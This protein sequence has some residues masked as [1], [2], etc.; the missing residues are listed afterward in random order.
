MVALC[1][2]GGVLAGF[3]ASAGMLSGEA[4]WDPAL[5]REYVKKVRQ[6]DITDEP[7]PIPSDG[8]LNDVCGEYALRM[9]VL[10]ATFQA[11]GGVDV[12][13]TPRDGGLRTVKRQEELYAKC[14]EPGPGPNGLIVIQPASRRNATNCPEGS[15]VTDAWG[16]SGYHSLGL[17]MDFAPFPN[18]KYQG[19]PTATLPNTDAL[20]KTIST[21][22]W[23]GFTWGMWFTKNGLPNPDPAHL[24]WH[25]GY[26]GSEA[27]EVPGA[28]PGHALDDASAKKLAGYEWKIPDTIYE[29]RYDNEHP[30]EN[31]LRVYTLVVEKDDEGR[32]WI[33]LSKYRS[34][35]G[36]K[37]RE[38]SGEWR[39]YQPAL[40]LFPTWIPAEHMTRLEGMWPDDERF[41]MTSSLTQDSYEYDIA[42]DG[43]E[44]RH[45]LRKTST[46]TYAQQLDLENV[47][48][49]AN[50][51]FASHASDADQYSGELFR[52]S[53]YTVQASRD[54]TDPTTMKIHALNWNSTVYEDTTRQTT[55]EAI[56]ISFGW[57]RTDGKVGLFDIN[58]NFD[59]ADQHTP[60]KLSSKETKGEVTTEVADQLP[61]LAWDIE[62]VP[63]WPP[64]PAKKL[65]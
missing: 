18:G 37:A 10:I 59:P 36:D 8:L 42:A 51:E 19:G 9:K 44:H 53:I 65:P 57:S 61:A 33:C 39:T 2:C 63:D 62:E 64:P 41:R 26:S 27:T 60:R 20:I 32:D 56:G 7:G 25:P 29:F 12:G 50:Q 30:F 28:N 15:P 48:I 11:A 46:C 24:E 21:A 58:A 16:P 35:T 4:K 40:K 47:Q 55:P 22:V 3:P 45:R 52:K 23:M 54:P 6:V 31:D 34:L 38:W 1:L 14:R 13:F 5:A 17:A 43:T 49:L